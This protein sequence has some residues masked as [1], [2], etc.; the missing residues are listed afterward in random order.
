MEH[1]SRRT[2]RRQQ[3]G[4][5]EPMPKHA[6]KMYM[7]VGG[8][9]LASLAVMYPLA[10]SQVDQLGH[11]KWSLSVFWISLSMVSAMGIIM[12]VAMWKMLPA[13]RLNVALFVVFGA[14][15]LAAF[16]AG[17]VE[18]GVGDDAFLR[19]MIPH[20]SR[21]IHMCQEAA[22][23]DPEIVQLCGKIIESQTEEISQ[24]EGIIARRG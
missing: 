10:F 22:L 15:L 4:G 12:L 3:T 17:R 9:L 1:A 8:S 23:A 20:H 14:L 21:A 18:A 13:K 7:K 2:E 24:M 5:H 19:S 6:K 11:I 16:A